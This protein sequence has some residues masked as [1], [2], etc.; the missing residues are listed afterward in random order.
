[1]E[2]VLFK[3]NVSNRIKQL[4]MERNILNQRINDAVSVAVES[5]GITI[6]DTMQI[7][8]LPDFSG[9]SIKREKVTKK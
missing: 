3:E 2:R 9:V 5:E 8:T 7:E 6:D 1:M 4:V